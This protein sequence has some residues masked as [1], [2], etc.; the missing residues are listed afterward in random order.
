MATYEETSSRAAEMAITKLK[1]DAV[2]IAGGAEM[3]EDEKRKVRE[4]EAPKGNNGDDAV[5]DES[6][7]GQAQDKG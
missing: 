5:E 6:L 4:G 3:V 2:N 1:R 7:T